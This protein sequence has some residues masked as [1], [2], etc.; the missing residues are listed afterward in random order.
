MFYISDKI[1]H[2]YFSQNA[3]SCMVSSGAN[4]PVEV[5]DVEV[6]IT[7]MQGTHIFRG[8]QTT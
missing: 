5:V 3:T 6:K 4:F 1:L 7:S 2:A 8:D